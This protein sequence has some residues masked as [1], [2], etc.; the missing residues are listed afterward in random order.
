M[1]KFNFQFHAKH[2]E[3]IDFAKKTAIDNN[4][5]IGITRFFP[6]YKC[7]IFDKDNIDSVPREL[8]GGNEI[9]LFQSTPVMGADSSYKFAIDNPGVL[10]IQ[11]GIDDGKILEESNLGAISDDETVAFWKKAVKSFKKSMLKGAWVTFPEHGTKRYDKNHYYTLQA[12]TAYENGVIIPQF[13]QG[14]Y[15]FL[16]EQE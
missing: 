8:S 3:L 6:K 2:D 10:Y 13:V 14:N 4:L 15:I 7:E 1:A 9:I 5:Y 12:K 11:V 16:L